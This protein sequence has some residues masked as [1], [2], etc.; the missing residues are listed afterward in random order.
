M[1]T[2]INISSICCKT[3]YIYIKEINPE[4]IIIINSSKMKMKSKPNLTLYGMNKSGCSCCCFLL[5]K[6]QI[7]T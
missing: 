7:I 3:G 5:P 2:L 6:I 4:W 1:D